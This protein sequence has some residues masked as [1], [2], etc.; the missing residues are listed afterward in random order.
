MC[1]IDFVL[2]SHQT[3][4]RK[5]EKSRLKFATN[6]KSIKPNLK[7]EGGLLWCRESAA[8]ESALSFANNPMSSKFWQSMIS[9]RLKRRVEKGWQCYALLLFGRP[10]KLL[11]FKRWCFTFATKS[12][13]RQSHKTSATAAATHIL[14]WQHIYYY[15]CFSFL[16]KFIL[17]TANVG[18]GFKFL[19]KQ[20]YFI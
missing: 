8:F 1:V 9:F 12:D 17:K 14:H 11:P 15:N 13:E 7:L 19:K 20:F 5:R 3:L 10:S 18:T 4:T 16:Y 2:S 6:C